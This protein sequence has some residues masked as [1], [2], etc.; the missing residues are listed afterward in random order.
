MLCRLVQWVWLEAGTPEQKSLPTS[1]QCL[2]TLPCA[3]PVF[4]AY[5]QAAAGGLF[6]AKLQK[7]TGSPGGLPSGDSWGDQC[8]YF[9]DRNRDPWREGYLR[10]APAPRGVG[11]PRADTGFGASET[12]T[13]VTLGHFLHLSVTCT[14]LGLPSLTV[15]ICECE[16]KC[17][18]HLLDVGRRGRLIPEAVSHLFPR[19]FWSPVYLSENTA[20]GSGGPRVGGLCRMSTQGLP[21]RKHS[22][23]GAARRT[24]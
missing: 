6:M 23:Q 22:A 16:Q 4:S 3:I 11:P 7:F 21:I 13:Q 24:R 17:Y 5:I 19:L 8:P 12:G 18:R 15:L 1:T 9:T 20:P 2:G 14:G 10:L